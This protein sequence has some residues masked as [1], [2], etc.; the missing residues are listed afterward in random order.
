[1]AFGAAIDEKCLSEFLTSLI[2]KKLP[3]NHIALEVDKAY[4]LG[5]LSPIEIFEVDKLKQYW[6][7][8]FEKPLFYI[9]LTDVMPDDIFTMGAAKNTVKIKY[10]YIDYIK[11]KCSEEEL[12]K[13]VNKKVKNIEIIGTFNVNEWNNKSYPQVFIENIKVTDKDVFEGIDFG[14][15]NAF[16][17]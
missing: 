6:C 15:F 11:F 14:K 13:L 2:N 8:G 16:A 17:I 10:N 9:K 4:T 12:E 1:M 5:E 3:T 7:K